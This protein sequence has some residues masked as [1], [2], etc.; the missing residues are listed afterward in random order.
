M[1]GLNDNL[2]DSDDLPITTNPTASLIFNLALGALFIVA[3]R[4]QIFEK[5]TGSLY[6]PV[7]RIGL[8]VL[9]TGMALMFAAVLLKTSYGITFNEILGNPGDTLYAG[10]SGWMAWLATFLMASGLLMSY[11]YDQTIAKLVAWIKGE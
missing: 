9:V 1:A 5:L 7:Q 11:L 3:F 2:Q 10:N 8:L 4:R 6:Y